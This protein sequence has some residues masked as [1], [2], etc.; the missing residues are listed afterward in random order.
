MSRQNPE[1]HKQEKL[2]A[3]IF[4]VSRHSCLDKNKLLNK[5]M[6]RHNSRASLEN[7]LRQNTRSYDRGSD[8]D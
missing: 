2:G 5:F 3:N 4:G 1:E 7:R 8:K 6:S